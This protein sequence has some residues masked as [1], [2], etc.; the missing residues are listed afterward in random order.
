[1]KKDHHQTAA[2]KQVRFRGI[3]LEKVEGFF[4]PAQH[5]LG[6]AV[7]QYGRN[8]LDGIPGKVT[9]MKCDTALDSLHGIQAAVLRNV[10]RLGGPR[11]KGAHPGHDQQQAF[12]VQG[13]GKL[14]LKQILQGVDFI[15]GQGRI[16]FNKVNETGFEIVV[17][18]RYRD[19]AAKKL[20]ARIPGPP[21]TTIA[22]GSS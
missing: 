18:A 17:A 5:G 7:V 11:R 3:V 19:D 4:Q 10:G 20:A 16:G 8:R 15:C 14:T 6:H 22:G 21:C 2:L 1:M 9:H 12:S 13:A